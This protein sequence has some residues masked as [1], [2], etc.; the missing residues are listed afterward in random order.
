M[1]RG[2]VYYEQF[3]Q[4]NK[5]MY[6][7]FS[8]RIRRGE[9]QTN[10][11]NGDFI[12][13]RTTLTLGMGQHRTISGLK[14]QTNEKQNKYF[15]LLF[16]AVKNTMLKSVGSTS[17]FL[18]SCAPVFQ[19]QQLPPCPNN[20]GQLNKCL[21]TT[22]TKKNKRKRGKTLWPANRFVIYTLPTWVLFEGG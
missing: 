14:K 20:W 6:T 12:S 16:F 4:D 5:T 10:Q 9:L 3:S 1:S 22:Q 11:V 13:W 15:L 18:I 17:H 19:F 2:K 8:N 7:K 21:F